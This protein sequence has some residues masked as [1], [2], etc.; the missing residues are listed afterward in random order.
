M[1]EISIQAIELKKIKEKIESLETNCKLAQIQ[2]KEEAQKALR[3]GE[4]VKFL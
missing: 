4:K 1:E 3:M 2:Q